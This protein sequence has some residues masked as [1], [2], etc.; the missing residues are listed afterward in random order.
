MTISPEERA[1]WRREAKEGFGHDC[2]CPLDGYA[3]GR[4]LDALEATEQKLSDYLTIA[5]LDNA[6]L[7]KRLEKAEEEVETWKRAAKKLERVLN[8]NGLC[9]SEKNCCYQTTEEL[10]DHCLNCWL[11]WAMWE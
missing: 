7:N 2:E 5:E 6:E 10:N 3:L 9:P 1:Y 4:L 11:I 8:E